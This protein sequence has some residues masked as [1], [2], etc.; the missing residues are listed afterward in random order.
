MEALR[1]AFAELSYDAMKKCLA[2]LGRV[3]VIEKF[4]LEK[5]EREKDRE[6]DREKEREKREKELSQIRNKIKPNT[7]VG[8]RE[9]TPA[10]REQPRRTGLKSLKR[11]PI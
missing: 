11:L 6:K 1:K 8:K 4:E 5:K 2:A 9:E 10:L 7:T 3:D